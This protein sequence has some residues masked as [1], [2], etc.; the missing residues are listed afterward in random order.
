MSLLAAILGGLLAGIIVSIPAGPV[1]YRILHAVNHK[2]IKQAYQ[3]L[4][5]LST[6]DLII[7]VVCFRLFSKLSTLTTLPVT[8]AMAGLFLLGFMFRGLLS[9][10]RMETKPSGFRNSF[11][12]TLFNPALWIGMI[13]MITLAQDWVQGHAFL[14]LICLE[15][16]AALWYIS[17][18]YWIPY[19]SGR[20]AHIL[21]QTALGS[22]GVVGLYYLSMALIIS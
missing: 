19:L 13:S 14:F 10:G 15:A 4:I 3:E 16:G 17:L 22:I 18:I 6:A 1:G 11:R 2:D 8:K 5:A 7:L 20:S 21:Q 12:L 9:K